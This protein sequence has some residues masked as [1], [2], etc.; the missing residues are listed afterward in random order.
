ML[1]KEMD[2]NAKNLKSIV[3]QGLEMALAGQYDSAIEEFDKRLDMLQEPMAS[4]GRKLEDSL[5]LHQFNFDANSELQ[6][7]REYMPAATATDC[8]KNMIE[9]QNFIAKHQVCGR[10]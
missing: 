1:E 3:A 2:A 10:A 4:R 6:W 8:G 5:R 7:I 9:V